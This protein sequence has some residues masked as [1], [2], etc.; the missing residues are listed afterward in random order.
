MNA[1]VL[2]SQEDSLK[3]HGMYR[4]LVVSTGDATNHG[5][6]R[7][8]VLPMFKDVEDDGLPLAKP[9]MPLWCG[10]GT[11]TGSYAVP[12]VGSYVWVFFEN[13]NMYQPVYFAEATDG[14]HGQVPGRS[15]GHRGYKTPGG[16]EMVV[17]DINGFSRFTH[18]SG[19]YIEILNDGTMNVVHPSGATWLMSS[20]GSAVFRSPV[21]TSLISVAAD[22]AISILGKK[23]A[24]YIMFDALGDLTIKCKSVEEVGG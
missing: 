23:P 15:P 13:G 9:A 18:P 17:D 22:G 8:R 5:Q 20:I 6:V 19:L 1:K 14:V 16:F 7:I 11:G 24:Q 3:F 12:A 4:G 21:S 2:Q 10:A